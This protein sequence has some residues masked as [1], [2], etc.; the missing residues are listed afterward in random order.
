[1]ALPEHVLVPGVQEPT[2]TP[3]WHAWLLQAAAFCQAPVLLQVWG[4]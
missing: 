3:F 2:Q 4:C 1:M